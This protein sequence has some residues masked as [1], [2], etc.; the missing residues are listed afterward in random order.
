MIATLFLAFLL[1]VSAFAQSSSSSSSSAPLTTS[2][3]FFP[4]QSGILDA[5]IININQNGTTLQLGCPTPAS[6]SGASRRAVNSSSAS[7]NQCALTDLHTIVLTEGPSG[8]GTSFVDYTATSTYVNPFTETAVLSVAAHCVIAGTT[9]GTCTTSDHVTALGS[10]SSTASNSTT[11]PS[12][13]TTLAATDI[14]MV[15]VVVT[16]GQEKLASAL[17]SS[18]SASASASSASSKSAA[19]ASA[20]SSGKPNAADHNGAGTGITGAILAGVMGFAMVA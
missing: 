15:Q 17:S 9:T 7:S 12:G 19:S 14:A 8:S 3:L 10:R 6:S 20:T 13:T 11:V 4:D 2:I 16:A 1:S 5:S 18:S